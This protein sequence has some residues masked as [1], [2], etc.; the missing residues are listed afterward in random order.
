MLCMCMCLLSATRCCDSHNASGVQSLVVVNFG[1]LCS[2]SL[3]TLPLYCL[4]VH[5]GG[6]FKATLVPEAF[7]NTA[8]MLAEQAEPVMPTFALASGSQCKSGM[9]PDP[10][11]IT[12]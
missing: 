5:M 1:Y 12:A 6:D 8:Q 10:E 3:F 11:N 7:S 4:L 2:M 9:V